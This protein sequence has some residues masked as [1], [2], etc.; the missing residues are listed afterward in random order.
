MQRISNAM[1]TADDGPRT[2]ALRSAVTAAEDRAHRTA[3]R[4]CAHCAARDFAAGVNLI[5]VGGAFVCINLI[6]HRIDAFHI[7]D[8]PAR[9]GCRRLRRRV[10]RTAT[11]QRRGEQQH[12]CNRLRHAATSIG[13]RV[14]VTHEGWIG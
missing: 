14:T 4:R 11:Q 13:L 3:D 9:C 10:M 7:D 8:D 6:F 12:N 2:G 1:R 5:G